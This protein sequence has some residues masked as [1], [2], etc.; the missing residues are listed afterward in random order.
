[1]SL[2]DRFL[3]IGPRPGRCISS[4][5]VSG[6]DKGA[7]GIELGVSGLDPKAPF[8]PVSNGSGP[9]DRGVETAGCCIEPLG[10]DVAGPEIAL[11]PFA[12]FSCNEGSLFSDLLCLGTE[13]TR[14]S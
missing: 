4:E 7:A 3:I 6:G 8:T 2:L 11:F 9:C 12:A 13:P 5:G 14:G 10:S 1:M